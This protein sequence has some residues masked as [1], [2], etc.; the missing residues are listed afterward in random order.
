LQEVQEFVDE[1]HTCLPEEIVDAFKNTFLYNAEQTIEVLDNGH[2]YIITGDIDDMWIR[3]SAAQVELY[4]FLSSKP[5]TYDMMKG[6]VLRHTMYILNDSYANSYSRDPFIPNL[7]QRNLGRGGYVKTYNYEV[8]SLCYYIRHSYLLWKESGKTAHFD[9]DY[10][11]AA[12]KLIDQLYTEMDHE[13][14]SQYRYSELPRD[15]LGDRVKPSVGLTWTGY[16]PSDDRCVYGY[17]IPDNMFVVVSL[18]QLEEILTAVYK[19]NEDH[20]LISCLDRLKHTIDR[21]ILKH[22]IVK[23]PGSNKYVFAYEVDG[24]GN[25]TLMDDANIPS[26][27][28]IPYLGYLEAKRNDPKLL[29]I[30]EYTRE[31]ILSTANKFYYTGK[32]ASGI[33]SPHTPQGFIWPMSL[34]MQA[35]TSQDK[36]EQ[37]KLLQTLVNTSGGTNYMHE[38]FNPNNPTKYTRPWF[39]WA[40]SL[41]AQ[42]VELHYLDKHTPKTHNK[43][44][45]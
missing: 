15:G 13:Y 31:Y 2:T 22:G 25:Y 21:A 44:G 14:L 32:H 39:G 17:H 38:S 37:E 24:W 34:I 1:V 20:E 30:Y 9:K 11:T 36:T 29:K 12:V 3:D 6:L 18:Q 8:D 23:F 41:F 45:K 28:S 40:N 35:W 33:G 7:H 5:C 43:I 4:M 19:L 27:L 42:L 16:R 26:L 10:Y